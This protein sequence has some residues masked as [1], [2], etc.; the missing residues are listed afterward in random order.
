MTRKQLTLAIIHEHPRVLLGMKKRGFGVGRWNGF[1][2]KIGTNETIEEAMARELKEESGL[3][4]VSYEK[5]GI[6][7]FE[8]QNNPEI[9]ETH[10]FK[11][12][13]FAKEPIE[14]EEMMPQWFD[15]N[16]I[17]FHAMWPD[18]IHWMPFFLENKLFK[19]HFLFGEGDIVLEQK[20]T[21]CVEL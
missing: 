13:E 2:G 9:L 16:N 5:L 10:V 12:T 11:V 17:P 19:G 3:E 6:L 20:L 18:D 8:F 1:G 15:I 14:T 7:N 4:V 21:E